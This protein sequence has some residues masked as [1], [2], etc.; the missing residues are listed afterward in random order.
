[1]TVPA[2][3][4]HAFAHQLQLDRQLGVGGMDAVCLA[5][6]RKHRRS[7]AISHPDLAAPLGRDCR[8]RR[9]IRLAARLNHP[10]SL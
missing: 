5:E 4:A 7:V 9:E 1:M 6:D 2:A 3:L 10:H 8:F